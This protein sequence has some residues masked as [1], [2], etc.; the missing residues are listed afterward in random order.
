[1][2]DM[3]SVEKFHNLLTE[4]EIMLLNYV[5]VSSVDQILNHHR[6]GVA[7]EHFHQDKTSGPE[8]AKAAI[9]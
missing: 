2:L 7:V 8:L 1:M 3:S 5:R 9:E 6:N 4:E